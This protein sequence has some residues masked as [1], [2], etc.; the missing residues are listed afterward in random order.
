MS[1]VWKERLPGI[2]LCVFLGACALSIASVFPL[3][4][5]ALS[6]LLLGVL[7]SS[8]LPQS[9]HSGIRFCEGTVL[10]IAVAGMGFQI[11]LSQIGSLGW[12][13]GLVILISICTAIGA[14]L[15]WSWRNSE[16]R[17]TLL[18]LG[19][20]TA[21]CGSSAIAAAAPL[22]E[23][24]EHEVGLS[25]AVVNLLGIL[26]I[27]LLPILSQWLLVEINSC[28]LLIGS[29]LQAVGHVAAAGFSMGEDIGALAVAVKMGRVAMLI[30]TIVLLMIWQGSK[31]KSGTLTSRVIS[32]WYLI[33]FCM[34][35]G[36]VSTE[37]LSKELLS[38]LKQTD[39]AI[40]T[41]AMAA[42]GL[43]INVRELLEQSRAVLMS[44]LM[45]WTVQ[46]VLCT[47]LCLLLQ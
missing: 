19:I 43:R 40:L 7:L 21:I 9:T 32:L 35:F 10:K 6:A 45:I 24:K 46:I 18:F 15:F 5:S 11:S 16:Q 34:A 31:G 30:P 17:S 25:V 14:A 1:S 37:I 27:V 22:I 38:I 8:F 23:H 28:A 39:K 42:I 41:V 36:I 13:A 3:A 20:G 4:G 33:L 2:L 26:G 47:A 12:S 44:G 29:T